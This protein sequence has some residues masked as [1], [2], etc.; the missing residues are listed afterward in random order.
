MEEEEEEE[1][2]VVVFLVLFLGLAT[3]L[4]RNFFFFK[5]LP[6]CMIVRRCG[7]GCEESVVCSLVKEAKFQ[8]HLR[9]DLKSEGANSNCACAC[10]CAVSVSTMQ[11]STKTKQQEKEQK[12][13]KRH[14]RDSIVPITLCRCCVVHVCCTV[15][16]LYD[17]KYV[18]G[19]IHTE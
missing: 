17:C 2:V 10:V 6:D 11:K 18:R 16:V 3:I 1:E 12:P 5:G 9:G 19:R 8:S 14:R 13:K 4:G 15:F 7:A